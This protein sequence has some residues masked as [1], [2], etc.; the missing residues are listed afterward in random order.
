ADSVA[1]VRAVTF[2]DGMVHDSMPL[3]RSPTMRPDIQSLTGRKLLLTSGP[4]VR[5][6]D[7]QGRVLDSLRISEQGYEATVAGPGGTGLLSFFESPRTP[8]EFAIVHRAIATD[9]RIAR[10]ADTVIR[11]I[12]I[13]SPASVSRSG[14]MVLGAGSQE[15]SVFGFRRTGPADFRFP[16]HQLAATTSLGVTASIRPDGG[17]VVLARSV[18]VGDRRLSQFSIVPP[19]GGAERPLGNP[20]DAIDWDWSEDGTSIIVGVH[21]GD[22]L[23]VQRLDAATGALT[24]L[25]AVPWADRGELVTLPGGGFLVSS[26]S[27]REFRRFGVPGRRDTLLRLAPELGMSSFL[28]PSPDGRALV[29]LGWNAAEDSI[30]LLRYSMTDGTVTP[31]AR[32]AGERTQQPI[33]LN[34]GTILVPVMETS[35]TL[36]WYRIPAAGGK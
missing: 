22:S 14:R 25:A 5:T 13:T 36:A 16:L 10:K 28:E 2:A 29:S 4:L 6:I 32:F 21:R 15:S 33:W 17:V 23:A 20:V 12:A 18:L 35:W 9:G 31:L 3:P 8:A 7:R 30:S 11:Q 24:D 19:D 26:A 34:D 1:W 27:G